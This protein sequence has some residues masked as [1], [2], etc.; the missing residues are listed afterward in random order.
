MNTKKKK[1]NQEFT[2]KG[3]ISSLEI[4]ILKTLASIETKIQ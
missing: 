1:K 3:I 4:E 2:L